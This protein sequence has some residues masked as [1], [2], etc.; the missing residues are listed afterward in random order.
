[1]DKAVNTQATV[2]GY[3]FNLVKS[4]K[5]CFKPSNIELLS[6]FKQVSQTWFFKCSALVA[7]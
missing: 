7:L 5:E 3:F 2:I 6:F 1:M 4:A